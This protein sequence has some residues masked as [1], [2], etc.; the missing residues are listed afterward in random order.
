MGTVAA[1]SGAAVGLSI[2]VLRFYAYIS[3]ISL[4][5]EA[6]RSG[7][8]LEAKVRWSLALELSTGPTSEHQALDAPS[9]AGT[10]GGPLPV[11]RSRRDASET[12]VR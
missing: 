6:L 11:R 5:R 8:S 1:L 4:C 12:L 3:V 7:R 10:K 9:S 2:V